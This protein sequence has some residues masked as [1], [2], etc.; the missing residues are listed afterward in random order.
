MKKLAASILLLIYFTVSTGFV[1]SVHYCMNKVESVQLG[2]TSSDECSKCGMHIE[3]S[4][5]CCKDDVKLVK[6]NVEHSFASVLL[7]D[8]SLHLPTESVATYY[9]VP[10]QNTI[11]ESYPLA[12]GPPLNRQELYLYNCV[13]RL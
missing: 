11:E 7:A 5:G 2:D 12:H 6:M 4:K 10:F 9:Y 3:G 13:F 1:V 8:F